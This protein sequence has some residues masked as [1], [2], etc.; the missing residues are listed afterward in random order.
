[1]IRSR[2]KVKVWIFIFCTLAWELL[3]KHVAYETD[4]QTEEWWC[5]SLTLI[6]WYLCLY[7][8]IICSPMDDIIQPLFC[9][10]KANKQ[11]IY[12]PIYADRSQQNPDIWQFRPNPSF[13]TEH[14]FHKRVR[15]TDRQRE[16]E[17]APSSSSSSLTFKLRLLLLT[18][19]P[20]TVVN[21]AAKSDGALIVF[22]VLS[23]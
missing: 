12:E 9:G 5:F 1:M 15:E 7:F 14:H 19:S 6:S 16:R 18:I 3:V 22:I 21:R 13:Q 2:F 11:S 20:L 8:H 10:M 23:G 4:W 17:I